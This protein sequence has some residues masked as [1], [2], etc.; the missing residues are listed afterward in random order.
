MKY[1]ARIRQLFTKLIQTINP[2]EENRLWNAWLDLKKPR[3]WRDLQQLLVSDLRREFK[4]RALVVL[5]AP[6]L[7]TLPFR[8]DDTR[9]SLRNYLSLRW[10]EV[11]VF[12]PDLVNFAG[13]LVC[14][15]I[16]YVLGESDEELRNALFEYNRLILQFLELLPEDDELANRLFSRYEINDPI[17]FESM[18]EASGYNP[19]RAI[20][21][22]ENLPTKWKQQADAKMRKRILAEI[23]G[24]EQPREEWEAALRCYTDHI[25]MANYDGRE[26]YSRELLASQLGFI[27]GL[28]GIASYK[29]KLFDSWQVVHIME[30]LKGDG[31]YHVR[32]K[33]ARLIVLRE[34]TDGA[35]FSVWDPQSQKAADLMR[36]EFGA[37][38]PELATKLNLLIS[39]ANQRAQEEAGALREQ[40]QNAEAVLSQMK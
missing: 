23:E 32:H 30:A 4:A 6:D 25:E 2:S 11:R 37:Q 1:V 10:L 35:E 9:H 38:D 31:L 33:L 13:E 3:E 24:H 21:F 7:Q 19:L 17:P 27:T 16:D 20:F 39:K 29:D 34:T 8:W 22:A 36:S 18:E 5:L 26:G 12:P 14:Q 28:P 40:K 15:N